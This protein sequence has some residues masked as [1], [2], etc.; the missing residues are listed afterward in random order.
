[1]SEKI[2]INFFTSII[3][4]SILIIN[5]KN[6]SLEQCR[7]PIN[8]PINHACHR[9]VDDDGA[10]DLENLCAEPQDPALLLKFQGGAGDGV[11]KAG[12]GDDR[13]ASGVLPQFII[14]P[15]GSEKRA[16]KHHTNG[17]P[18]SHLVLVEP[19]A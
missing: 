2:L 8:H 18:Q 19:K 5:I 13:A 14:D 17:E 4:K 15:Q 12:D 11:G 16:Q 3:Y 1:M 9:A 7:Y 10:G 6:I